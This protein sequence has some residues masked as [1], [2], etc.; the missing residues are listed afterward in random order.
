MTITDV[1][2]NVFI[3]VFKHATT[4][5]HNVCLIRSNASI[6]KKGAEN[7]YG[8]GCVEVL[9]SQFKHLSTVMLFG[10]QVGAIQQLMHRRHQMF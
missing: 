5:S 3:H 9:V 8:A 7:N 2:A 1:T 10:L 6:I 4:D